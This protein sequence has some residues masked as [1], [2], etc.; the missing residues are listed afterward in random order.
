VLVLERNHLRLESTAGAT[1]TTSTDEPG[2]IL[3][4]DRI[5]DLF[6]RL[7]GDKAFKI[8]L[9]A[10]ARKPEFSA[11]LNPTKMLLV[12]SAIKAFILPP[13]QHPRA[14]LGDL[15]AA[16]TSLD[17]VLTATKRT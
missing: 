1:M 7:P 8:L 14:N 4:S 17:D 11:Q 10:A 13:G 3:P 15:A 9:P 2:A 16:G 5:V 6:R 12:A